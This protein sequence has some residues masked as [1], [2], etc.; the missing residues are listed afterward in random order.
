[1]ELKVRS[2]FEHVHY[3]SHVMD[4]IDLVIY[5]TDNILY[6]KYGNGA[7][8]WFFYNSDE[9]ILQLVRNRI[10]QYKKGAILYD[11]EIK[12][13]K[14]VDDLEIVADANNTLI[15]TNRVA[16]N[17]IGCNID[18]RKNEFINQKINDYVSARL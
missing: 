16:C 3:I 1:M 12:D 18:P 14:R 13:M 6:H 17:A 4:D 5:V 11:W 9:Y 10:I 2:F 7:F 8:R 15:E